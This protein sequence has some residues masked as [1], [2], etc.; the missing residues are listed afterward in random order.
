[1]SYG[2]SKYLPRRTASDKVVRD[3]TFNIARNPN[4]ERYQR[5]FSWMVYKLFDE[6]T[7][8]GASKSKIVP[9][10]ELVEELI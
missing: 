7:S 1:M 3:K 2:D 10:K 5:S 6:K 9:N 8:G 4:Y